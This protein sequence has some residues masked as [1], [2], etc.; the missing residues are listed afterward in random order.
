MPAEFVHEPIAVIGSGCRLPGGASS[1]SKLWE[2]L[3][4]PRDLLKKI[5]RFD[6]DAF[7]HPDGRHH[8]TANVRHAHL[9][10]Q[11][12][13]LFDPGFF[14]IK[15]VEAEAIDPLQR[16]LLET[17]YESLE[18]AGIPMERLQ[19]SD[20]AF[21]AG[22]MASDYTDLLLR[23]VDTIPQYFATA[24]A[25]SIISN[26][27]S[28]VFD[29]HGP[30]MTVDTA[31][32]S[33]M[34]ALHGAVT[35]LRTGES[36]VAVAAGGNLILGP[37]L[38]I[39]LSKV[40]MASPRGRSAMWDMSAD[41]Y[42]R[43]EGFVS[44]VLKRLGDA[45][46]DGD[47]ID[48]VIRESATNQDGRTMGITMPSAH[49]QAELIR[50]AYANV[51]LDLRN[52]RDRP[53]F[54]EAHGTGTKAGDPQEA[55]ALHSALFGDGVFDPSRQG[56]P[57]YVGSIK[58]V[59][60][61]TEGTA[62][63]AGL[64]KAL[65]SLQAGV[66]PP[67][68]LFEK[69]NPDLT[70]FYGPLHVPTEA[71]PWPPLP[72]GTPRRASVNSFGFGGA[73][74][75]V[76]L[77]SHTPPEP[78]VGSVAWVDASS[79][80]PF[81]F[82][83]HTET[84]LQR[85]LSAYREHLAKHPETN[86][87]D[88]SWTLRA[89]RSA[90][91]VKTA[92]S[93]SSISDL[94][95]KIGE[96][97][98]TLEKTPESLVGTRSRTGKLR[99]LGVFTGQGAQWATMGTRLI[100]AIPRARE[101]ALALDNSLQNL[102]EPYRPSWSIVEE[103]SRDAASSRLHE[104]AFSQPLC[105]VVQVI[106]VD[107]LRAAG[108]E[109]SAVVGHSSGEIG[110]A[111]AAG[112]LSAA[113]A[114][115]I[116]YLRGF[117][118]G[119]A[120]GSS[121]EKG[122]MMAVGSSMEDAMELCNRPEFRGKLKLAACNSSSSV[123][124]SGDS[125]AVSQAKTVLDARKTFARP[126]KVDTA[127]HS[128]HMKPCAE[129]YSKGL[130]GAGITVQ[131]PSGGCV[132]YSSVR[133]GATMGPD[134]TLRGPYW[135]DNMVNP[136]LFSQAVTSAVKNSGPF[137]FA[138]EVGPHP[139]L[140]GPA[141]QTLGELGVDIPYSGV[142]RRGE[143]DLSAFSD[144]LGS[145]W[146][147]LGPSAVDFEAI[148]ALLPETGRPRLLK[149]LPTYTWDHDKP[150]WYESRKSKQYR[151]QS[152]PPHVLLGTRVDDGSGNEFRW[153]KFLSVQQIPWLEGHQIQGQVVFP[154]AGYISMVLEAAQFMAG[155]D[156]D[157]VQLLE[158]ENLDI[159]RAI[160][161]ADEKTGIETTTTLSNI[162]FHTDSITASF[163]ISAHIYRD[164]TNLTKVA[165]GTVRVVIATS[166][167]SHSPLPRR[168][169]T[170]AHLIP[171]D[172][173][174]FYS[175][176]EAIGYGY[177]REFRTCAD[178]RRR[179][180]FCTG[181]IEKAGD[182]SLLVHPGVLDHA[183]QALFG[184]YCWPGDG[185][186]WTLF[187]PRMVRK[188]TVNPSQCRAR[189]R[190]LSF[191]AWLVDSP[192]REM[193][194]DVLFCLGDDT[195]MQVEGASMV[196]VN[197]TV[198]R[199]DRPMF[200]ETTWGVAYPDGELA[201][202]DERATAEEWGMA[203]ACERVAH[204]YWRKLDEALSPYEREHCAEHHKYLLAAIT[205]L[206]GRPMDGTQSYLKPEWCNDDEKDIE[207]LVDRYPSS[208]DIKLGVSVGR[209][210]PAVIRGETS[211]LE[212]MRVDDM[213]DAFHAHSLGLSASNR[214]L[215]RMVKQL[216]HRYPRMNF[217]EIGAATGSSTQSVLDALG[218]AYS[219][220]T[221]TDTSSGFFEKAAARFASAGDKMSFK[222]LDIGKS[223]VDQGYAAN[224]YDVVI[225]AN[226]FHATADLHDTLRNARSLLKPG[227]Y[228]FLLEMTDKTTIRYCFSLG[229]LPA[230]WL[231]VNDGRP[232]SPC[233]SPRQWNQ[234]LRKAGFAGVDAITPTHDPYPNPFSVIA[235]QAVDERTEQLRRLLPRA[236][237][238]RGGRTRGD[239]YILGGLG[240]DTSNI[241]EDIM[242]RVDHSFD[243]I[244]TLDTL[245]DVPDAGLSSRATVLN[246]LDLDAPV[247]KDMNPSR[248]RA[249]QRL[250][251]GTHNLLW[252]THG[253]ERENPWSN[254]SVGFLRSVAAELPTLRAQVLDFGAAA[255]PRAN[256]RVIAEAL[257]RLV[258]TDA[259]E[260]DPAFTEK[261]LWTT[262]PEL[263]F[264]EG[265][266]WVPRVVG[267]Q[268][269]DDRINVYRRNIEHV[270]Q[271][272]V[273]VTLEDEDGTWVLRQHYI[274]KAMPS[275]TTNDTVAVR[276]RYS[277][278]RAVQGDDLE[279]A[280]L[281]AVGQLGETG[282]WVVSP[283]V[284]QT[285]VVRVN[286]AWVVELP[287]AFPVG[288][289]LNLLNAL[290]T[291][292]LAARI[293][294]L[295]TGGSG[296]PV[297]V[298][299]PGMGLVSALLNRAR[300]GNLHMRF[301]TKDPAKKNHAGWIY[302]HP[303]QSSRTAHQSIPRSASAFV[304]LT[305]NDSLAELVASVLPPDCKIL[306]EESIFRKQPD[307]GLRALGGNIGSRL[308]ALVE[309]AISNCLDVDASP[310][311]G[312]DVLLSLESLRQVS[313]AGQGCL[314]LVDWQVRAGL[315]L[316]VSPP[317]PSKLFKPNRSYMLAGMTG[318]M[319]QS[320]CRW[321]VRHG[322]GAVIMT[323]RNPKIDK[324]W[325]D[326]LEAGGA[327]IKVA[328]F[329]ATSREAW[330]KFAAEIRRDLPPVAGIIN[331]VVVLQD[332]FFLEMDINTFNGTLKPK[333]DST[334]HLN[335]IF[336]D[337]PLD[338]FLMFSSLSSVIG[339]RGQAN[340]NAAN[341][342]MTSLVQQRLARGQA[343][344]VLQL[345]S[346]VGV[347][348]LTRAG[349]V[350]EQ[351]LVKYGYLP[352]SE[353]DLH[354]LVAQCIMAGLPGSGENSDLTTGL[355]YAYEDE[356][357]GVHWATNPR[358]S[359]M[360]L[361]RVKDA[362]EAGGT[363][364]ALSTRAQLA[365]AS[366]HQDACRALADCFGSK[367]MAMLQMSESS[368]R[369]DAAL[370]EMGVDSLVAV[371]IRSWFLKEIGVDMAVLKIL[372]GASTVELCQY[373]VEQIPKEMLLGLGGGVAV[374][375]DA[376]QAGPV[377]VEAEKPSD[378]GTST[379]KSTGTETG[380]DFVHVQSELSAS[381]SSDAS[382]P[383]AFTPPQAVELAS[384]PS[385]LADDDV[386]VRRPPQEIMRRVRVSSAQSR[387]WFLNMF[388]SDR[389]ASN[390]TL[391]YNIRGPLRVPDLAR[392]VELTT[393]AH[394][395]LRTCFMA[396]GNS[397]EKAWQGVMKTSRARFIHRT[398]SADHE[399]SAEYNKAR[400]TVYDLEQGETMQIVLLSR[401]PVTHTIIFGYHHIV[402][403]GVG[404]T[405]FVADLERAYKGQ[406]P[407]PRG[408]QYAEFAEK[409]GADIERGSLHENLAYW[410]DKLQET[411]PLLP[412][413]P[414]AQVSSRRAI[415]NYGSSYVEHR[416]DA[417][418]AAK[419]KATCRQFH[420]T[421]SHFYLAT[422]RV[423]LMR[424]A[425]VDDLCIG[426]ADANRYD[427][428][429]R[430]TVGLFLNM[431]PLR[432]T[433]V[434]G[435]TFGHVLRATRT[436][437]YEG[438]GH[439]G[440]PFDE[441]LQALQVSRSSSHS[442]LFQAFFDYHQGAQEKLDFADT[443]WENAARNPGE[444]AYDITLDVVEGS[445]GSLVALIGQE[446]LY[447][448][449]EMQK[450]LDCYLTLLE[451]FASNPSMP[452][453]AAKLFS[454]KEME[455]A[456]DLG[457]GSR[458]DFEWSATLGHRVHEICQQSPG[459]IAL[460]DGRGVV[461]LTYRQLENKARNIACELTEGGVKPGDRVAV[462]QEATPDWICSVLAIFWAGAVYVPMVL[463]NPVPRLVSILRAAK[464]TAILAH[465]ATVHLL[466]QLLQD[467]ATCKMV[468]V[469]QAS[470]TSASVSG[471]AV[472]GTI[473]GEDPAVILFTSGSTGTPKGIVLRHRN[474]VNHIEG[475]VRPWNIGREVVLQQS[476]FSFDLSIGQIFTALSLGGTLVVAPEE[477]RRD[478]ALLAGLI[479][480]EKITWTLLTPSEYSGV[481]QAA[482][483]ELRLAS[484]W[485]HALACGEALT[486]KLVQEFVKLGHEAV[487]LYNCY[488]PA[489][490]I[491]SATMAEIPLRGGWGNNS[492]TVGRPNANYS[493]YII[494]EKRNPLP[495]GF[496]GEIL[497]G[498][499]GV[500]VGYL[501]EEQLTNDRFLTNKF[502]SAWDLEHG[503][504][505]SYRTGDVGR[506]RADGT[507]M[508]EGRLEGDSQVKIRGFRVDLL[509]IEST[510]LSESSGVIADA[511]VTMRS[512]AQILVAHVIFA[513]DQTLPQG[514][515]AYLNELLAS[516]PLPAYMKPTVV[517]PVDEIPKNLHAKKDRR[518]LV[519]L[520]LPRDMV[521]GSSSDA[522][523]STEP[524]SP[525]EGRLAE[526]WRDVLPA[527]FAKLFAIGSSTDF[528]AVG[529][530]SLLLVKLQARIR[531]IFNV[532]LPLIQLLDTSVLS[533][534]ASLVE[535]AGVVDT[536]DWERETALDADPELAR[537]S[538]LRAESTPRKESRTVVLT[539]ATGYFGPYLLGQLTSDPSIATIHCVAVRAKDAA[540]ARSRLPAS[541]AANPKV[542]VHAGD[543]ALSLLG[544]EESA[545]AALA[546]SADLIIHSGARRSFWDSYYA[547]RD[548]NV[549]STRTL[550]RMAAPR[551][552]PMHFPSS[553]GVLLLSDTTNPYLLT[554]KNELTGPAAASS[555]AQF[556]PP[557]DGSEGYVASKWASEVL[558]GKAAQTLHVP[559][560]IHR[561]T[562]RPAAAS[563]LIPAE[564]RGGGSIARS[565][566]EDLVAPT[567]RL[568]A[569]PERSTWSGRFDVVRSAALARSVV[570]GAGAGLGEE[571]EEEEEE[572][573]PGGPRFVHHVGE[574]ALTPKEL[575]DF[576]EERLGD[577][578][579]GRMGLL[580]WVG[581]IKR[582]GYGWLFSTHDL[583]LTKTEN[584]VETTLVNRR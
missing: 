123:T 541:M 538:S 303:R 324:A 236:G 248:L 284:E 302:L 240:L 267:H 364:A 264:R 373:A 329:D 558:L 360:L 385:S 277:T 427:G 148:H 225:A 464:P 501:N 31:C 321:M 330:V 347:G 460:R 118:A 483:Q 69:L 452:C 203:E 82:S 140:K 428:N 153:R 175:S 232:Y 363:K 184:A 52:P 75:H 455:A 215:G 212:H 461:E 183:F 339:N 46:R 168:D 367:L 219:S 37:E 307:T 287:D 393:N 352:V 65:V 382:G 253:Q 475:Y 229:S 137:H 350:M 122:A 513:R 99:V 421:S 315:P 30:S 492:V 78:A 327:E 422:F 507:L 459:A 20:T 581:A 553:S 306:R 571:E 441:L 463:L 551:R 176:L 7:Y 127:Y 409:E 559:V 537:R 567:A 406:A 527:D 332:Q 397:A 26:R 221:F 167:S 549:T 519:Q 564:E 190:R 402:L 408:L 130:E 146:T 561:F 514:R 480:R 534:M 298:H 38:F 554:Q 173:G 259:W 80:L 280:L 12:F 103:L 196:A 132:W 13:R 506:L 439:A 343:A 56:H 272:D 322:A 293:A 531:K 108:I 349:D 351:I 223:P 245:E 412:L 451:Q 444:R 489:E 404:F 299:E 431:L 269:N 9:L 450:L 76:I 510:L 516:L 331:G 32:S 532:S 411:P 560:T 220:Y 545:F 317:D 50:K 491:V 518:A 493:I 544:L 578:V 43:G 485:R 189:N 115:R 387:F 430:S 504:T 494:D 164:A 429:V 224:S 83:A 570:D 313:S 543:L 156:R 51:G 472:A 66:I 199:D 194:G 448:I 500:G 239:L 230:W 348:F 134:D 193:R 185:R 226:V 114:T 556:R 296:G 235:A 344:S 426:L 210:L 251:E 81:V 159:S 160:V 157:S 377:S 281:L 577:R 129:P 257:L 275:E 151:T 233:I 200:F 3:Q 291:E 311:L 166:A 478:P 57:L 265:K 5:D 572:G 438:L 542:V 378:P 195:V 297:V 508:H 135:L 319:G 29:W 336:G 145:V 44:V 370:I 456:L 497:I 93:A 84:S 6:A 547:L 423:M 484:S 474:L 266:L 310:V 28:Y 476:A 526:A 33:S 107:F 477:A 425:G 192:S 218:N 270:A 379:P 40:N 390:V 211:M 91:P 509:D 147:H 376:S 563:L 468:N 521:L 150:Y 576:L 524:S 569:L 304:H 241:V 174:R 341:A 214:W 204:Y 67:N 529:G 60:G 201:A 23:D 100:N 128:H 271:E 289:T 258:V 206:L 48:C 120:K 4:E 246:L 101:L 171:V 523:T 64:L 396:D 471:S 111:H 386:S 333:V 555:V 126:L 180:D 574:A 109:F 136:V 314:T 98:E 548:T 290:L 231:G 228:L 285:S 55:E 374:S 535:A 158:V 568:G 295:A 391:S 209:A 279:P 366:T 469:D 398:V 436:Q 522:D 154:A 247:F 413:L 165:D 116:A 400:H 125:D 415:T 88:L 155:S 540:H 300:D 72:E 274:P 133:G 301:T 254:A 437:V 312:Q 49:A 465:D 458:M 449:P 121:G 536:V 178:M 403:D 308:A 187:L 323:S 213:L 24:T 74:T 453:H 197:R 278:L 443:T 511:A 368:F 447:G 42:G 488:G 16:L 328:G 182:G 22:V 25:R 416:L 282:R 337:D 92:I 490:A 356:D 420:V 407:S 283:M 340:Y 445:A 263:R 85:M 435:E 71:I 487:R 369:P 244:F 505:V 583:A 358:F 139:A 191:D 113:D 433:R 1:P 96:K 36:Q 102:P 59:V 142:L 454:E 353:A 90:L 371:E 77:E 355:R 515:A 405:A 580:E 243:G 552:I 54:F 309:R 255:K 19:G 260:R 446:Y 381:Y 320:I 47:H 162:A 401:N 566:L 131:P 395:A 418:L 365:A 106:M 110:A 394:E 499:C 53:Q 414:V 73:N 207:A 486:P 256:T 68:R 562:P 169:A 144:C 268:D 383:A 124:L 520:P 318:E 138:L 2:L 482:P 227:G 467:A 70:P 17:V 216:A 202:A 525:V 41:G 399:T 503:W 181:S 419:L 252:V 496:P 502:E 470:S 86:L 417:T 205:H 481:L 95:S 338:F 457:R 152:Q 276:V 361:P 334:I 63:L 250:I 161:F 575:F 222:T 237:W 354:H 442:P 388:L 186:F 530:N 117:H 473:S 27:V 62:G 342:F 188:I 217:I 292:I 512:E 141:S 149:N 479:R 39:A 94:Q 579:A 35:S 163:A 286:R 119:L 389:T 261:T 557:T 61:H 8:G 34:L 179:L 466:P 79:I 462:L 242:E 87:S 345:G 372:G 498:G 45:L 11:D 238:Q 10:D 335:D 533:A 198:A 565:A 262:E 582:E 380:K 18:N 357:T 546:E 573:V 495:Q 316:Q 58:T 14:G 21:Y 170:P 434:P 517:V 208:I 410:K 440:V 362:V 550:L 89:R 143:S 104:A 392:A 325:I 528:F 584:G 432:L 326:E 294:K 249:L 346:V 384:R 375:E 105:T 112:F 234:A 359:H 424:L 288:K 539:G 97:L 172:A 305:E 273:P 15:P 177:T